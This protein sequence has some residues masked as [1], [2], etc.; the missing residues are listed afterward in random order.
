MSDLLAGFRPDAVDLVTE[1]SDGIGHSALVKHNTMTGSSNAQ[2]P[3]AF[4]SVGP[5][6]YND[7]SG[8]WLWMRGRNNWNSHSYSGE[9]IWRHTI[10][11]NQKIINNYSDWLNRMSQSGKLVY[12]VGLSS[13]VTHTSI[14]LNLSGVFNIGLHPF[15][16]SSQM[17]FWSVGFRPWSF[18]YYL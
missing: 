6:Y 14:A 2:D 18:S 13:C 12:S 7:P 10:K 11:V 1:H 9:I 4:I 8:N 3:N 16:L 5:D 17:S 15:L